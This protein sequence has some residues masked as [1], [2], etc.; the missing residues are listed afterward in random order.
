MVLVK[1]IGER[2]EL[3]QRVTKS[4]FGS[5]LFRDEDTRFSIIPVDMRMKEPLGAFFLEREPEFVM[6]G[7]RSFL[8]ESRLPPR[9]Y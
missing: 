3:V 5:L 8:V 9:T 2:L 1:Q 4:E 6:D 7:G